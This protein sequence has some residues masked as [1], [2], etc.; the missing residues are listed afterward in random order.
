[1][2][3]ILS[4]FFVVIFT[5]CNCQPVYA[6]SDRISMATEALDIPDTLTLSFAGDM[7]LDEKWCTTLTLNQQTNGIYDCISSEFP[8]LQQGW[9]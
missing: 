3:K 9:G 2:K 4:F 7:N 1:M 5:I 8:V 6:S